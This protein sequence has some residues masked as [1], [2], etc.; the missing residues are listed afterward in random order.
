MNIS[1]VH[2]TETL[3][4]I[5]VY[6]EQSYLIPFELLILYIAD[7]SSPLINDYWYLVQ[8]HARVLLGI[9]QDCY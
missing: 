6:H 4:I 1:L 9:R 7:V 3:H 2:D 8:K 5:H